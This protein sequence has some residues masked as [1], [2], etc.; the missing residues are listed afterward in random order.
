MSE[1]NSIKGKQVYLVMY[2]YS[3][4][5]YSIIK[6]KETLDDAFNYICEEIGLREN[7]RMID[8]SIPQNI[9]EKYVE[10]FINICYISSGKYN[11]FNLCSYFD[12]V[13][14]YAIVPMVI[15]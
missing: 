8:V 12:L 6:I 15:E 10:D 9:Q 11:K 5:D 14:S 1:V 2:N 4:C 13:S 7:Y 3:D